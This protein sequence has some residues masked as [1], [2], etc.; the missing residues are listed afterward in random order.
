[1][2]FEDFY[3]RWRSALNWA[4]AVEILDMS[5]RTFRRWRDRYEAAKAPRTC[6]IDGL[7]RLPAGGVPV[8]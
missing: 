1:M 5:E 4:E 6:S 8:D 7:S 3:G 2:K